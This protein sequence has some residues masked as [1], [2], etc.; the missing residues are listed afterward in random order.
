MKRWSILVLL[1]SAA[2]FIQ[3]K[4]LATLTK[5]S[6]WKSWKATGAWQ[7][8]GAWV[9]GAG[10]NEWRY[11]ERGDAKW[12]DYRIDYAL[13]IDA[14]STRLSPNT[15]AGGWVWANYANDVNIGGYEAG[16]ALRKQGDNLYRV[17]FSTPY[18]EV[19][20]WS[21]RGGFLQV[22]PCPLEVGK[23]YQVSATAQGAHLTV[24][25]DGKPVIDYWDRTIPQLTG[26]M[27]LALHE[28]AASFS[29]VAITSLPASKAVAPAHKA[30]FHFLQW[31]GERWAW[32]GNEPI[33]LLR[34][35][36]NGHEVKLAPGYQPQM[37]VYW[38][39]LNY[40]DENFY[41]DKM[42]EINVKAEGEKLHFEVIATDNKEKTW[43]T[44]RT[45]VTV[46]YDAA[47]HRYIYDH[48]SDLVIPEGHT[49]RLNHPLEFTDP[50]IH[51][52]VGSAS[53]RTVEWKTPHPWSVY[54]HESG[55]LYKHPHNHNTWYP[56]FAKPAWQEA[57]G[58]YLDPKDGFWAVVGDPVVNPVFSIQD[59][60]VKDSRFY[61]ELCG[62]AFDVHMRWWPVKPGGTL[63]A[64]TYTVKWRMTSVDGKQSDKWLADAS[65]LAVENP[66][67]KLLVYTGGI[68][69]LERFDQTVKWASPFY[70]YPWG[71]AGLQ[72]TTTGH[73][74]KTSLKLDGPRMAQT[75]V[76]GSVYSDPVL[77]KTQY[78]VTAW[79]KTKDVQGE[80]PGLIFGGQP[81]FPLITGTTDWQKI[82]F[83]CSPNQ[84]L[85]T[86]PLAVANSGSGTVWFDDLLIRPLKKDEKPVAPIAAAPKPVN[87]PEAVLDQLLAWS[88]KSEMK[89][90][91]RTL[92]DLSKHGNHGRLEGTATFVDD[93]GKRALE[94][95]ADKGY[96]Q[97]GNFI[98]KSPQS[99]TIWVK[100]GKLVNDWNMIATG[101]AW[102]RAW[103]IFLYYKQAPY[104]IDFRPW[105]T[106]IFVDGVVPQ[107][108]WTHIA[109][110]D[111]GKMITLYV[112]GEK[113]KD[114][115]SS[116]GTWAAVE[117]PLVL[118]TWVYYEKPRSS[119][120][121]R[122]AGAIYWNK[123]LDAAAVKAL[124]EQGVE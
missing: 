7:W 91:G 32:D 108:K 40:G 1:L 15:E 119:Y 20:L 122:L 80:G 34:N 95:E 77:E 61:T 67:A 79:V 2:L 37:V 114:G 17:M 71:D 22:V 13:R 101:G 76:G 81:Y 35:D 84:P 21:T 5:E 4:P 53:P 94:L 16:L 27:A 42:K 41:A 83:A 31:K 45:D 14:A 89:D 115:K 93:N 85:H 118:G 49:L 26:S 51:G 30:E 105:G 69:H 109:A 90:P 107:D 117:G 19:M 24:S 12:T 87:N 9:G 52:H 86:V 36:S 124:F 25:I 57:R 64:D 112:N 88:T 102:N 23:T 78:E 110:V 38:H 6:D 116:G 103:M 121:G 44:S 100:P 98:F 33:F 11:A 48:V 92:L 18:K 72:D 113:V 28:G 55:K 3:A 43:L 47:Q 73:D 123:A 63:K 104:S 54:K 68:G 59:S 39:W 97:G 82:G 29:N 46:V 106:R 65:L 99:F 50:C 56:G 66:D 62:W 120:T 8:T 96:A 58:N 60:S 75:M 10:T 70:T 74:D 111:D